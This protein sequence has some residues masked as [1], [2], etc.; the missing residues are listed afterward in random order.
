MLDLHSPPRV[1][2]VDRLEAGAAEG[3]HQDRGRDLDLIVVADRRTVDREVAATTR[4][5]T[6]V[7]V[8]QA[9][10]TTR[11][12]IPGDRTEN[13]VAPDPSRLNIN[14]TTMIDGRRRVTAEEATQVQRRK[15]QVAVVRRQTRTRPRD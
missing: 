15:V 11:T 10:R 12:I 9:R 14:T 4:D 7:A 1:A 5:T 2:E 3:H 6:E 13:R 8:I